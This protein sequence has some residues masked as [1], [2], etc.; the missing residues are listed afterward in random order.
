M[1]ILSTA[2]GILL[3]T[4]TVR[5]GDAATDAKKLQGNW[6]VTE[7]IA[8]GEKVDP[9]LFKGTKFI[10][11]ADKLT[12]VPGDPKGDVFVGRTIAVKLD[13]TKKPAAVDLTVLDGKDKGIVSPGVY[14][15]DG[16]TLRWCQPDGSK[17]KERPKELASPVKSDLYLITLSRAKK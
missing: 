6:E 2:V 14:A 5:A 4:L 13:P 17:T 12:I 3:L 16:D 8:Y 10:F 9:K 15:I 1:R 11:K 7:L